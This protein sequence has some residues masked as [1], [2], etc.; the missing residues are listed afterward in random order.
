MTTFVDQDRLAQLMA[1]PHVKVV[2][3]RPI[4]A[5]NG[6]QLNGERRGGHIPGATAFP[7]HW[8][9]HADDAGLKTM[10]ISKKLTP[11]HKIVLY[12]DGAASGG[13]DT[14][15]LA[16]RLGEIGYQDLVTYEAGF[17]EWA[18]AADREV[19]SL[20]RCEQLV[21]PRWLHDLLDGR[22]VP[23]A[24][25]G[26]YVVCHVNYGVP[27]E[28]QESHLPGAL[29]LDTNTLESSRD[30][31]RRSPQALEAA[32]LEMGVTCETTV[33]VYGRDSVADPAEQKPG[34][35]AGQIAATRAAAILMY[36]GVRD[37]RLLD[38]GYNSWAAAGYP[39]EAIDRQPTPATEFGVSIPTNPRF[40][41]DLAGA[42]EL[43]AADDGVLVSIRSLP[44]YLGETSG[45]NYLSETGDIPGAV[46]GNCGTNAYDMQYYRNVD[47]TMKDYEEIAA[48]WEEIG[49]TPDKRVAFYCGTG[50]R[51]SE[52]L[53]CAYLMGWPRVAVYD[54]G[55]FEWSRTVG[56]PERRSPTGL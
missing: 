6:W 41:V 40:F 7:A 30:W 22:P 20:P 50:W 49:I 44:E 5:F 21:P 43:L 39:V 12:G 26:E 42:Q 9:E 28:Y 46:W 45:Y 24:P 37:V 35:M 11:G 15:R 29:H 3:A 19:A 2:D 25:A 23:A 27:A 14:D 8:A 53:L 16:R 36:A 48:V 1:D 31:N 54:G 47:N 13:A 34:R 33:I 10:L 38:G 55:W 18:A 17:P 56:V 4:A 32:L 52:T 51:A